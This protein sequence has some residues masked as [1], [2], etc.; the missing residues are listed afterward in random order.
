MMQWKKMMRP[1]SV[2]TVSAMLLAGCGGTNQAETTAAA[3]TSAAEVTTE[4]A[5]TETT[6]A[7]PEGAAA[8]EMPAHRPVSQI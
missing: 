4:A 5:E 8:A 2:V 6:A 7:E 3:T 1:V